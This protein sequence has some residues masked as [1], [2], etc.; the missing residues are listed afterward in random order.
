MNKRGQIK[1][2][3]QSNLCV[4]SGY[5]YAGIIDNDVC[6]D[7]CGLP[8]IPSRRL[9]GCM[10]EIAETL[11]YTLISQE[12]ILNLFGDAYQSHT[13]GIIIDDAYIENYDNIFAALDAEICNKNVS[14]Q[15]VLDCFTTVYGQTK[16][17]E[18]IAE[19]TSLR[20]TRVINKM[21]PLTKEALVFYAD[22]IYPKEKENLLKQILQATRHIGLKRNRGFGNIK[23]TLISTQG[24]N[25]VEEDT[26]HYNL[27][28]EKYIQD[29]T[30]TEKILSD[31]WM[32]IDYTIKNLEP[33]ILSEDSDNIS[34]KIIRGQRVLGLLASH[35]LKIQGN[36]PEDN[37]FFDLF[38]NG[39][40]IY[41]D[42]RPSIQDTIYYPA[43]L[44]YNKL[45]KSKKIVN[46]EC[47][48][49]LDSEIYEEADYNIQ[50]GNFPKK[51]KE[52]L[53]AFD[54]KKVSLYDV[55][56]DI[57]YHHSRKSKGKDGTPGIL[58]PHKVI[59]ENQTFSGFILVKEKYVDY[60]KQLL[61]YDV[62]RF[63]KSRTAQYGK[64]KL[65][66]TPVDKVYMPKNNRF[67]KGEYIIVTLLSDG[68]FLGQ[69]DYTVDR[70]ELY[71]VIAD[72][73]GIQYDEI[74][75]EAYSLMIQTK[76]IYGY[77]SK[78]NFRKAPVPVVKAGS[79][80]VYKLKQNVNI[81]K[82]FIGE[83]NLE[84]YGQIRIDN[85]A[86]MSYKTREIKPSFNDKKNDGSAQILIEK[87]KR[88][89]ILNNCKMDALGKTHLILGKIS[90][91]SIGKITLMLKES[92]G[93][94]DNKEQ[95]YV[96]FQRKIEAIKRTEVRNIARKLVDEVDSFKKKNPQISDAWD[97]YLMTILI[98][99]KYNKD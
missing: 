64:C 24:K 35:Y 25:V 76:V 69:H 96:D 11:L 43:P 23:C 58:Y 77:Q 19:E 46:M 45:K 68:I 87:I 32:R 89:Q 6:C 12:N 85:L 48:D 59:R 38:L 83:R 71:D 72:K 55:S 14:R 37:A 95:A 39:S 84:G 51:I 54:G 2:V 74:D 78:W 1:I 49:E 5:A 17:K 94:F 99:A 92:T 66:S 57:I 42:L 13:E 47:F 4:G 91:S 27:N 26:N 70:D 41:S 90:A 33:L 15:E 10:R 81:D 16:L 34:S 82:E 31:R 7:K 67:E 56:M 52:E 62:L 50:N 44:Y 9:K 3:L 73:L 63:G 75:H 30:K 53:L 28:F 21:S 36:T 8:Y 29:Y 40:T 60:L 22:I 20:Y 93:T 86:D 65:I 18:G 61:K 98:N 88:Q 80:F 79:A 97:V